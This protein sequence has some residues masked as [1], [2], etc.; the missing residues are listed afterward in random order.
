M[1]A[2]LKFFGRRLRYLF[3]DSY[4]GRYSRYWIRLFCWL[5]RKV[6]DQFVPL[7]RVAWRSVQQ[8]GVASLLTAF[9]MALGIMLVV[10]VLA[11]HGVIYQSFSTNASLGYNIIIGAKG[12]KLQLTLNTVYYLSQPVEN[13]PYEFY[14]E[15]KDQEARGYDYQFALTRYAE[16][17]QRSVEQSPGAMLAGMNGVL[18][19]GSQCVTSTALETI[20]QGQDPTAR[21]G[22][23]R[24]FT[25]LA[26]PLC[27]GDYY[28][29]FRVV[30][31][32]PEMFGALSFGP[33]GERK[34]TFGEGRNFQT[35]NKDHGYFEAVVGATV[36]DEKGM[37]LGDQFS[38]AHGDPDGHG[39][40]RKFTVVGILGRTG[41]PND[42]AVF[43]N[44]EGFYL[45]D[46]HAKPIES[47]DD[48][49][50]SE[51]EDA[52]TV[53]EA[54]NQ[55]TVLVVPQDR[56][57]PLPIEQREVTAILLRTVDPISALYLPNR[58][59]EGPVA[60]AV[61]PTSEIYSLFGTIVQPILRVLVL[62]T[63]MICVVSGV[64]ILVSI[65]NSMSDRRHEIAVM[66]ALGA[67]RGTVLQIV[68]WESIILSVGGGLLGWCMGHGLVAAASP[69]IEAQTGVSIGFFD[70][71]PPVNLLEML[72]AEVSSDWVRQ[73]FMLSPE[74][75][76]IPVL[77]LLAVLVGLIPGLAAYRTDVAKSLGK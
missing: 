47:E 70:L 28:G 27:L 3:I 13:I 19:I 77:I 21:P 4:F 52:E 46:D 34:Y 38:P 43:I 74:V 66:R 55:E 59:N 60:Q 5:F 18:A 61:L 35:W 30:G 6:F 71:A 1:Q 44:M 67:R 62:L 36:A 9:S 20:R 69:K 51:G 32:T 14:L 40:E 75:L 17:L 39:H 42:R 23:F 56:L 15:F 2:L 7:L 50:V 22:R 63:G 53:N 41:T 33:T 16:H 57:Q 24:A 73:W 31:T 29:R 37:K 68:L 12:G 48:E 54:A 11:I 10:S 65:Y 49:E 25:Q 58:I 26:I 64:S 76:L 72:G 8:R 45:M